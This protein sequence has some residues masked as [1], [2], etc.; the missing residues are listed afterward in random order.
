MINRRN[1]NDDP[2]WMK[3]TLKFYKKSNFSPANKQDILEEKSYDIINNQMRKSLYPSNLR[4]ADN[5][6]RSMIK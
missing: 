3:N 4:N 6:Y 5:Y 1:S 2:E